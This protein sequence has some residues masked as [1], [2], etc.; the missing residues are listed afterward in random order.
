MKTKQYDAII[1]G[2]GPAGIF[3]AYK[4]NQL[5]PKLKIA[6]FEMGK[7][8]AKRTSKDVMMGFGGV[9]TYSDGKLHFSTVL[10]QERALHLI[11]RQDFQKILDEVQEIFK[12]FGVDG[13]IF[14]TDQALAK[15]LIQEAQQKDIELIQRKIMHV[16]TDKLPLFIADFEKFLHDKKIDIIT[17]TKITELIIKDKTCV[18]VI[19]QAGKKYYAKKTVLA[20][21][22]ISTIW[23]QEL[24]KKYGIKYEYTQ[25]EIGVRVEFPE[26]I[27]KKYADA[28]YEGIFKVRTK[29]FDDIIRTLC[30][31][32]NGMVAKEDYQGYVCVNGHSN[33][34]HLSPNSNFAF[35]NEVHLTEP[36]ENTSVYAKSVAE[37][38]TTLG[39]GKPILQ[40]LEDLKRGRRSTWGRINKSSVAP[41]LTDVTPGDISMAFPHRLV[42]NILEGLEA[43][44][45]VM[46]GINSGSTLLY[47]PEV[48][49]RSSRVVTNKNLETTLKNVYVAGDASGLSGSITGAAATGIMAARG[50]ARK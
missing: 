44:D 4:L 47:A 50:V 40:R 5:K 6:L 2:S 36:A 28:M 3:T 1:V 29:T 25:V 31:C 27:Y 7:P 39:G 19:D 34:D 30:P 38:A 12:E 45:R 23:L 10:S 14:P 33:S 26:F 49:F 15:Q 8:I 46:P 22:R 43:L 41:S 13:K 32:P 37:L 16:G 9:G 24:G 20:P 18:G 35:V 48:K 11:N 21:G 42:T 17:N